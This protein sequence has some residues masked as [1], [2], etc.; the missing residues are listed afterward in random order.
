MAGLYPV[1]PFS[2]NLLSCHFTTYW[3]DCVGQ[4]WCFMGGS[5]RCTALSLHNWLWATVYP[6]WTQCLIIIMKQSPKVESTGLH[7]GWLVSWSTLWLYHGICSCLFWTRG[8]E[9][10]ALSAGWIRWW[11][12]MPDKPSRPGT[13][14]TGSLTPNI[15]GVKHQFRG[16]GTG[17]LVICAFWKSP[18]W[19]SS[20]I[21]KTFSL[22]TNSRWR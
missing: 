14:Q 1:G 8:E 16:Q 2:L 15:H 22:S 5:W 11:G 21:T 4:V 20:W 17:G 6:Q 3:R 18:E 7:P 9:E 13:C 10:A 12:R 19:P